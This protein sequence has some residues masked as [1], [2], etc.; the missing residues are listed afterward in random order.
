MDAW[1]AEDES[2]WEA[3]VGSARGEVI[4]KARRW[5]EIVK[6]FSDGRE[7]KRW[8]QDLRDDPCSTV[9]HLCIL[10]SGQF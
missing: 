7:E 3:Q 4:F 9:F 10:S 1:R 6:E 8:C 5:G 2:G